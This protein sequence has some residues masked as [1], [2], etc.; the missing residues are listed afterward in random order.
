MIRF[1]AIMQKKY[2]IRFLPCFLISGIITLIS[3]NKK[4][5]SPD[6]TLNQVQKQ[7]KL[8]QIEA[9]AQQAIPGSVDS[10]GNTRWIS[11]GLDWTEG[12]WPGICWLMY[13]V[14]SGKKA[15]S[16]F[17][18]CL[19]II[20]SISQHTTWVSFSIIPSAKHTG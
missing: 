2:F 20:A 10:N 13:Q 8:M 4:D 12:F 7:L 11:K 6:E 16:N 14:S 3:C 18:E 19:L 5:F 1:T 9:S 15:P 17:N